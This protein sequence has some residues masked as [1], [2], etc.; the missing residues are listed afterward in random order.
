MFLLAVFSI[1]MCLRLRVRRVIYH[2]GG[3]H[4]VWKPINTPPATSV[5]QSP[6]QVFL[7]V[8]KTRNSFSCYDI[9]GENR[10]LRYSR[11]TVFPDWPRSCPW[12]SSDNRA[13]RN[14]V[15]ETSLFS[16]FPTAGASCR[17]RKAA[18]RRAARTIW[19]RT[20]KRPL[21]ARRTFRPAK[22]KKKI[23]IKQISQGRRQTAARVTAA[24]YR[25]RFTSPPHLDWYKTPGSYPA[26]G[27]RIEFRIIRRVRGTFKNQ[28]DHWIANIFRAIYYE[29]ERFAMFVLFIWRIDWFL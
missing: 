7:P 23:I 1:I 3:T 14:A 21:F 16:L 11:L 22:T 8:F 2:Y 12:A 4:F 19:R 13:A 25:G 17:R 28:Y 20:T 15:C 27:L 26:G 10:R 6:R 5:L 24:S 29:N 9:N 18:R